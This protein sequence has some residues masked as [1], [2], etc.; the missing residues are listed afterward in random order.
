[1][2]EGNTEARFFQTSLTNDGRLGCKP[3]FERFRLN[4]VAPR[5]GY[6]VSCRSSAKRERLVHKHLVATKR[7]LVFTWSFSGR[8]YDALPFDYVQALVLLRLAPVHRW[9]PNIDT[10]GLSWH[11]LFFWHVN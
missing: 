10:P 5:I 7:E 6:E 2:S 11:N 9:G 8:R 1:M 4:T 3:V